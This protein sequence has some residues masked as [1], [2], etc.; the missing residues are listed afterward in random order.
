[1]IPGHLVEAGHELPAQSWALLSKCLAIQ[2][3]GNQ[4]QRTALGMPSKPRPCPTAGARVFARLVDACSNKQWTIGRGNIKNGRGKFQARRE[5][6]RCD[7]D[8][9]PGRRQD[10]CDD[11][12][13]GRQAADGRRPSTSSAPWIKGA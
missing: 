2:G 13:N 11:V 1:M 8:L 12:W 6:D 9:Q 5:P 4:W 7:L 3:L 10:R